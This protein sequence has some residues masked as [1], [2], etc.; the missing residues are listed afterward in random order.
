MLSNAFKNP[1]LFLHTAFAHLLT[2]QN[3]IDC[4][5]NLRELACICWKQ[6]FPLFELIFNLYVLSLMVPR[7]KITF[8]LIQCVQGHE[9]KK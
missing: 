3:L 6:D 9:E 7:I 4:I 2:V 5:L 8:S 1:F